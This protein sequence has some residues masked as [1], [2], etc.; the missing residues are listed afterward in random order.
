MSQVGKSVRKYFKPEQELEAP[1]FTGQVDLPMSAAS[2]SRVRAP[3]LAGTLVILIFVVGFSVWAATAPLWGAVTASGEIR[4]EANRKTLKGRDGGL[5]RGIYVRE[6]DFVRSGQTLIKFD[7]SAP[8]AQ[9]AILENQYAGALMQSARLRAE[10]IGS[11]IEIPPELEARKLEPSIA[12]IID[13]ENT[14]FQVR[15]SATASQIGVLRERMLQL[16][17]LRSGLQIQL[18]SVEE[19]LVLMREE[20]R[21]YRVVYEQGYASRSIVNRL[22]RQLSEVQ[23]RRGQLVSEISKNAQQEGETKLQISSVRQLKASEAA[24]QRTEVESRLSDLASSLDVAR[25]ILASTSVKSPVDGYVL[26]L[27]QFTLG[28]VAGAGEVLMDVVPSASPLVVVAQIRPNDID[29]VNVGMPTQVTLPAFSN[30]KVPKLDAEVLS[31]SADAISSKEAGSFYT[32]TIRILPSELKKVPKEVTLKPG[33]QASVT[34]KTG[35]RTFF[36]YIFGP[37]RDNIERSL[38]EQ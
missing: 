25:E 19:Q 21:G 13:L 2:Q 36:S 27:S 14:V 4:V 35:K 12:A 18:S 5:I 22:Q 32:A 11:E 10:I 8:S 29:E 6:G 17:S 23:G 34:I 15:Q 38:R 33:M 20:I 7:D 24:A 3:I 1:S 30:S 16:G 9:V 26:G 31:V 28:G 37:I